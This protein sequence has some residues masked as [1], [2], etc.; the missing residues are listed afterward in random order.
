[1]ATLDILPGSV[2]SV[3]FMYSNQW[4]WLQLG[5]VS[6]CST[7]GM[8]GVVFTSF[9]QISALREAGLAREMHTAGLPDLTWFYMGEPEAY[10]HLIPSLT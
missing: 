9:P 8:D 10:V 1:M 4:A 2:S 5:K 7:H 3:Y 6:S